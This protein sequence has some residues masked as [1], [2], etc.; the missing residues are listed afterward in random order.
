MISID[1]VVEMIGSS[2]AGPGSLALKWYSSS[3]QNLLPRPG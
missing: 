3:N 1:D 2:S